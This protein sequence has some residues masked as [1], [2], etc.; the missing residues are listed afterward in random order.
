MRSEAETVQEYL[1]DLP[2]DRRRAVETVRATILDR[3][4]EGYEEVMNW[5]M[6][7]YEVPLDLYPETYNQQPLM[8]AAL[9]SQKNHMAVYLS[10][11]YSDDD[12]RERF[13][14]AYRATGKP[15]DVG[16]S[17]VRF[18]KLDDLPLELIGDAVAAHS[19]AD[20]VKTYEEGRAKA[21][22]RSKGR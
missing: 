11:I 1:D 18:K 15:L 13:E 19:I 16:K 12:A 5:G 7:T 6:I 14:D 2:D 8:Y 10:G 17:C 3:L 22:S 9:A 21:R 4:P 20:F